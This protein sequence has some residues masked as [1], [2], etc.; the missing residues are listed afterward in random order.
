M[1]AAAATAPPVG[2]SALCG[3]AEA[4]RREDGGNA[5]PCLCGDRAGARRMLVREVVASFGEAAAE[6]LGCILAET[7]AAL[8][9]SLKEIALDCFLIRFHVALIRRSKT[10]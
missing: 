2:G 9:A 3:T 5:S 1:A 8:L 4:L 10:W 7:L 6:A